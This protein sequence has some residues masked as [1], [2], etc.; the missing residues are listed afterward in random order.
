MKRLITITCLV[1]IHN[2]TYSQINRF[3]EAGFL[4]TFT[5]AFN[6]GMSTSS[7]HPKINHHVSVHLHWDALKPI[8]K[9]ILV[10]SDLSSITMIAGSFED[11]IV[12]N[13]LEIGTYYVGYYFNKICIG[14][15]TLLVAR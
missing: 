11:Q 13:D 15:E 5:S 4:N 8:D 10:K 14:K 2:F 12:I 6:N 7:V 9:V 3:N 1:I